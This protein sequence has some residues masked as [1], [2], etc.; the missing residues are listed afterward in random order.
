V[1]FTSNASNLHPDDTDATDDVFVRDLQADTTTLVSRAAGPTGTKGDNVSERPTIS[2]DGRLVAFH[3]I[4][5][6]LH[7]DDPDAQ[8]DVFVRDVL[9]PP[10]P[11][12]QPLAQPPPGRPPPG[13]PPAGTANRAPP[14]CPLAGNRIVGTGGDDE[15]AGGALSDIMLGRS[16]DDLLRGLGGADCLYGERGA[17]R[18]LGGRG[19]DR[20]FG[21]RGTDRLAGGGGGDLAIV[22]RIDTT[23]NCERIRR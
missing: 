6:S 10:P 19:R 7:P 17:D 3:S 5:S 16:G 20:V 9:G 23:R 22:D 4:A 8:R 2:A 21:G 11:G 18:L 1:G 14:G 12:Q 15:R 13:Q